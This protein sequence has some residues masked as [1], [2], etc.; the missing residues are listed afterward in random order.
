MIKTK[1][2]VHEVIFCHRPGQQT[3]RG[4]WWGEGEGIDFLKAPNPLL[5]A[6][7]RKYFRGICH[8][9]YILLHE[10]HD[11]TTEK[12]AQ[13]QD[14][15]VCRCCVCSWQSS[16]NIRGWQAICHDFQKM[17]VIGLHTAVPMRKCN[18]RMSNKLSISIGK[19]PGL[20]LRSV[21]MDK[22]SNPK[23]MW[24]VHSHRQRTNKSVEVERQ[25]K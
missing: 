7:E 16:S 25:T 9:S 3:V 12:N 6:Y 19:F 23:A 1:T 13:T 5:I 10:E 17:S 15:L 24:N 20:L 11:Q 4:G 22:P 18:W 2:M 14:R 21:D 8:S